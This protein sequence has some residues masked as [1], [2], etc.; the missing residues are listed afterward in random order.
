M[1]TLK[2]TYCLAFLLLISNGINSQTCNRLAKKSVKSL[3]PFRSNGNLNKVLLAEGESAELSMILRGGKKYR[4]LVKGSF[5]AMEIQIYDRLHTLVYDNTKHDMAQLWD[6]KINA[7]QEYHIVVT[8]PFDN[9]YSDGASRGC[10]ALA[11][12]FLDN[13]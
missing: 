13:D 8:A 7:T 6:F 5:D 11:V 1:R 12:G 9:G 10:V 3:A 4:I 2:L